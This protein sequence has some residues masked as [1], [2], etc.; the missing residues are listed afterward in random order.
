MDQIKQHHEPESLDHSFGTEYG[1][2]HMIIME[3]A[4]HQTVEAA[5]DIHIL[6]RQCRRHH[7]QGPVV[8]H[9]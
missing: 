1:K 8:T 3:Q 6:P 5:V 2:R 7:Q 9:W 4:E